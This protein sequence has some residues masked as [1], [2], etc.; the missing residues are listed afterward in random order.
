[1]PM[2]RAQSLVVILGSCCLAMSTSLEAA[3]PSR[4]WTWAEIAES[5]D[6]LVVVYGE[7]YNFSDHS[8]RSE[9]KGGRTFFEWHPGGA[10]VVEKWCGQDGSNAFAA[11]GPPHHAGAVAEKGYGPLV[12]GTLDT[13]SHRARS[14]Q[15][16]GAVAEVPAAEE[17]LGWREDVGRHSW[18]HYHSVAAKFPE[19][20]TAVDV[21]AMQGLVASLRLYPCETCRNALLG[22][23]LDEAGP[24]PNDRPGVVRWWCE[25]HNIVN[26]DVG[27]PQYPCDVAAL[28]AQYRTTCDVCI[29][30]PEAKAADTFLGF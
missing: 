7:V 14:A 28:D 13:R 27:K 11:A 15:P 22:G 20:A 6:C 19:N 1:M 8:T 16:G 18:F 5:E 29:G 12:V 9:Q 21:A 25:L 3:A 23:E 30:D 10:A 17:D 26:R 4:A 2:P 24:I